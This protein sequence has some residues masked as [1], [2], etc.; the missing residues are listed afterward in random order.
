[1]HSLALKLQISFQ[2]TAT[3]SLQAELD[4]AVNSPYNQGCQLLKMLIKLFPNI[5]ILYYFVSLN[6]QP[7][8]QVIFPNTI[9]SLNTRPAACQ[10]VFRVLRMQ[11][12][13]WYLRDN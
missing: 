1:M 11:K 5:I 13:P 4:P 2:T 7:Y 12:P 9:L 6:C 3:H 10:L 8:L